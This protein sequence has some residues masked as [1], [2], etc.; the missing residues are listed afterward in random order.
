MGD[1]RSSAGLDGT[2]LGDR[3][4]E[5]RE[6][7]RGEAASELDFTAPLTVLL[8]RVVAAD[9]FVGVSDLLGQKPSS[10]HSKFT[11]HFPMKIT[12]Y[13]IHKANSLNI[14]QLKPKTEYFYSEL[15]LS[16]ISNQ[17]MT[18]IGKHQNA[19]F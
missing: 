9:T 5:R 2:D 18:K 6:L 1:R 13:K 4:T 17:N 11:P 15:H 14:I 12:T 10:S 3:S 16:H 8:T 7:C 19:A